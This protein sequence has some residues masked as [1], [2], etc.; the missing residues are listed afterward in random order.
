MATGILF[1]VYLDLGLELFTG[2]ETNHW[3]LYVFMVH[4][5]KWDYLGGDE[6]F[7]YGLHLNACHQVSSLQE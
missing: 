2:Y 1:S 6:L 5:G 4:I 3:Y 7:V